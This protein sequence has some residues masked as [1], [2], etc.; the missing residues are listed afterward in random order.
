MDDEKMISLG[1]F[2]RK[3]AWAWNLPDDTPIFFGS[4]DLSFHRLQSAQY[5]PDDKTPILLNFEFNEIYT[6]TPDPN[7]AE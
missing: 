3:L 7:D 1:H 6:V 4:G 5:G 2:K